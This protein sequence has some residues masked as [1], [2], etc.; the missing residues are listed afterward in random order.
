MRGVVNTFEGNFLPSNHPNLNRPRAH[1]PAG[2]GSR[3]Y[4]GVCLNC[5]NKTE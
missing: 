4:N 3:L 1:L 5:N 2:T